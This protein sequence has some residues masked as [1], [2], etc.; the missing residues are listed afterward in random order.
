MKK[1]AAVYCSVVVLGCLGH[2]SAAEDRPPV[3]AAHEDTS[4]AD[5]VQVPQGDTAAVSAPVDTARGEEA[6]AGTAAALPDSAAIKLQK[7]KTA[8]SLA[9]DSLRAAAVSDSLKRIDSR[10]KDLFRQFPQSI[11]SICPPFEV[12]PHQMAGSAAA[13]ISEVLE[14]APWAVSA[15]YA[16][17]SNLNRSLAYGFPLTPRPVQELHPGLGPRASS[18]RGTDFNSPM[19]IGSA[20]RDVSGALIYSVYPIA[21]ATP[22]T[23]ILY[24]NGVFSEDILGVRFSR[25]LSRAL[26][27]SLHSVYRHFPYTDYHHRSGNI[28][29][30]Y[31]S[32][33]RDTTLISRI[34]TSP[35]TD[36]QISGVR[37]KW[38]R[39]DAGMVSV[40]G[41]YAETSNDLSVA[42]PGAAG[43][44]DSLAW[45]RCVNFETLVN[46][47]ICEIPAACFLLSG[48]VSYTGGTHSMASLVK[49]GNRGVPLA[50]GSVRSFSGALFPHRAFG[51]DTLGILYRAALERKQTYWTGEAE[52]T[53]HTA[54]AVFR[55]PFDFAAGIEGALDVSGGYAM[56]A[57]GGLEEHTWTAEAKTHASFGVHQARLFASHGGVPF[58]TPYDSSGAPPVNPLDRYNHGGAELYLNAGK[59]SVLLGYAAMTGIRQTTA[60]LAWPLRRMPYEQPSHVV[61]LAPSTGRHAGFALMSRVLFSDLQPYVKARTTVSWEIA[62]AAGREHLVFD[63]SL[64]YWSARRYQRFGGTDLWHREIFDLGLDS[65]VRIKT[66]TLFY[67]IDNLLNM[68]LAYVPG[69]YMPGLTFRWGFRW[70]IPG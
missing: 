54:L 39:G 27:L 70:L 11:D 38:F 12:L 49:S 67:K 60:Q 47:D 26:A 44:L 15:P 10:L 33:V 43:P 46:A 24:E 36:E 18:L 31:R 68:R 51:A 37:L 64:D 55:R 4:A 41:K 35:L 66:F 2:A 65:R 61:L 1:S 32:L 45:V 7:Q 29:G 56:A 48:N 14:T 8:D 52:Y 59:H 57:V 50:R 42:R 53:A 21:T 16:L 62:S 63:L 40:D 9:L 34:G 17:S 6:V 19:E 22:H 20:G 25:P 30:F 13:G 28:Y 69:Y 3:E 5:T 23:D 58:D